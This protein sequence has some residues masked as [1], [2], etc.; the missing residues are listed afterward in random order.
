MYG[1]VGDQVGMLGAIYM[2]HDVDVCDGINHHSVG[3]DQS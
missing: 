3:N 2:I 1:G